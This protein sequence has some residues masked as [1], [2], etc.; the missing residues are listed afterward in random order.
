[1]IDN[2]KSVNLLPEYLKTDKNSKF[3]SGTLDPLIQTPQLER[4]DGFVGSIIT[5]NYNPATDFYLKENLPLRKEYPLEPALVFKDASS[6][7]TDVI[8]FDDIIN[9]I[10]L[11]GGK[12]DN[13]DRLFRSKFYSYNPH[14]D[15]DKLINYNQYYW[16]PNGPDAILVDDLKE[17]IEGTP[18]YIILNNYSLSNGMKLK[19]SSNNKEYYVEGV[20]KSIKLID[21]KL[22]EVHESVAQI[23]NETFD[24][25]LFDSYPFDSNKT[26]PVIPEY[27]TI[28]KASGDL[29]PW[30]RYNR[31]FHGDII[32][33]TAE[34]NN[35]Q[36]VYPLDRRANR[37][38]IEF[39]PDI[40]LYNFGSVGIQNVDIIDTTTTDAFSQVDG[41]IGYYSDE[42]LLEHGFRIIFNADTSLNGKIYKVN[43]DTS[44]NPPTLRLIEPSTPLSASSV[45]INYGILNQGTSWH[46][47]TQ[48]I[49]GIDVIQWKKSQQH[50][51]INQAPLFDLFDNS[52]P[53]Q[54]SYSDKNSNFAGS[55]IFGYEVGTIYDKV[56]GFPLKYKN[57]IGVGSYVFKNYF[58]SDI[59]SITDVNNISSTITT[60]VTYLKIGNEFKNVWEPSVNYQIPIVEIQ[61]M[62]TSTNVLK[63]KSIVTSATSVISYVNGNLVNS[64]LDTD[65]ITIHVSTSSVNIAKNDIVSL[66]II[67]K[68]TPNENGYYKTPLGLTNNPL[69]GPI[70]ELTL[71]EL[72]DHLSTMVNGITGFIGEFP[73][74]S[75][76]RDL[77]DYA[78]YGSRLIINANPIAFP[79]IFLGKKEHNVVDSIRYSAEQYDQFKINFLNALSKVDSQLTPRDALDLVLTQ[80]N[81]SKDSR[82]LY[83]RSDM[84]GYGPNKIVRDYTVTGAN[85][86]FPIGVKFDLTALSFKSVIVYYNDYQL[87]A[88]SEYYFDSIDNTIIVNTDILNLVAGDKISIHYYLDTGGAYIPPTPSKL[89]L[90]PKYKPEYFLDDTYLNSTNVIR[91]HDGSIIKAFDDYRDAIILEY[92]KRVF[93]NIKI[94]YNPKI[95]DVNGY[96]PS[97]FRESKYSSS[98]INDILV[99]DFI[100]WTGQYSIDTTTNNV[101]DE[102]NFFTWNYTNGSFPIGNSYPGYWRGVYKYFYDTD[103]P[104]SHPW[105]MLGHSIKPLW[106]DIQYDWV[107]SEKRTALIDAVT[108]GIVDNL[109]TINSQYARINFSSIVPVDVAGNLKPPGSFL[110]NAGNLTI[111]DKSA[112]WKFGD[113][114]PAETAWRNSSYWPFAVNALSALLDPCSYTSSMFDTSRSYLNIKNQLTYKANDL[115]LNPSK[116]I[117]D[118]EDV[119][120]AG[121]GVYVI[122][123]GKQKDLN[124]LELL[125][126][127]LTYINFNL[128]HKLGGFASKDKLQIVIDSIDPVSQAQGAILP[129]EDYSLIL[130]VSNPIKSAR[131]SGVIV[132]RSN[133][134]FII[135]GYDTTNPYFEILKPTKSLASGAITVGGKSESFTEWTG[136]GNSGNSGLSA[137]D[138][139]STTANTTHYYK[140][141]QIVRYNGTF[142]IVKVGHNTQSTFDITLFQA[143][144][145][146]PMVG[147]ATAQLSS[148]FENTVTVVPYGTS[149]STIQEVYDLLIGYGAYLESQGFIFDEYNTDLNDIV[150]WKFTAKEFLYWTTQNWADGNLITLSPFADYLK[151]SFIDSVVDDITTGDYDF[152]ILK[153][154]GKSFPLD[155]FRL[156]RED[157]VC[158]INTIDTLEGMF[159][160]TLNSVQKEHGMVF[161]NKTIFNDTIYDIETG[162]KQRRIKLS[163]F[164]TANWN[165]DLSSPGFVYDNVTIIDWT[166]YGTYLPGKVVRYNGSYYESTVKII[167]DATFDFE[168]WIKLDSKPVSNLLP[169]FDYKIN[170]FEDFYSLDI[171]NF[172]STQQKLAQHLI[173]YTPRTYLNNIFTNS[174]SQYKFYQGYIKEKGTKNSIDKLS[175]VGKFTRQGDI[176]LTEDWAF[177]SGNY[178]SFSTYNEIEFNLNE[179]TS[180]ENPYLVKFSETPA[181]ANP[182]VTYVSQSDLLL[183]PDSYSSANTFPIMSSSTFFDNNLVLTTAG[184][185]RADD[186]TATAYNKNSLLDIANNSVLQDGN[187]IWMGFLENGG[188]GVSRYS[189]QSS[190]IA[191]VYVSAPGSSITFVTDQP[192]GL[193]IGDIV[194]VVRFN[195][196]VNGIHI[197]I[198]IAKLDQFT[199]ASSLTSIVDAELL[200]YGAL[201]K[202]ENARYKNIKEVANSTDILNLKNNEKIWIDEGINDKWQVYEK[203]KNYSVGVNG[204]F[205]ATITSLSLHSELGKSIYTSDN[206]NILMVSAPGWTVKNT[207]GIGSV[208][209]YTK[210]KT[211]SVLEKKF[212][213]SLNTDLATYC[214]PNIKAQFGYSLQ[215][216]TGKNLYFAG[217]PNATNVVINSANTLTS[218]VVILSTGTG[219][220]KNFSSEGLVKISSINNTFTKETDSTILVNPYATTAQTAN[221]SRFGHS[222]YINETVSTASTTLLVGAPSGPENPTNTGHV[223]AYGVTRTGYYKSTRAEVIYALAANLEAPLYYGEETIL[224]WMTFGLDTAPGFNKLIHDYRLA[225]PNEAA[226]WDIWRINDAIGA[227]ETR[228]TVIRAYQ[229]NPNAQLYPSEED[230]RYW[231]L[232]GLIPY[233]NDPYYVF[234]YVVNLRNTLYPDQYAANIAERAAASLIKPSTVISVHPVVGIE[235]SSHVTLSPGSQFGHKIAGD[236][237]GTV[238]AISAPKHIVTTGTNVGIVQLY[239]KD[240]SWRQ[241]LKSPFGTSSEFGSDVIASPDGSHLF[242]SSTESKSIGEPYGKVAV[243]KKTLTPYYNST[244]PEVIF[245]LAAEELAP[246]YY[247]E[248]TILNWMKV[249]LGETGVFHQFWVDYRAANPADAAIYDAERAADAFNTVA[250]RAAVLAAYFQN[251]DAQLYPDE[252]SIR[253]W[254]LNGLAGFAQSVIDN[255]LL[256]P[257]QYAANLAERSLALSPHPTGYSYELTQIIKNPS[258]TNDLKFGHSISI[259]QD[260]NTL[261]ISALGTNNS[262]ITEFDITSKQ[263]TTTFDEG[264]TQFTESLSDAGTVYVYS[265]LDGH[266]VL[267][268]E[269]VDSSIAEGSKYGSSVIATNNNIYV[270][271]PTYNVSAN[272]DTSSFYQFSK[273][274]S[275]IGSLKLLRQQD[276]LVD[277]STVDRIALIDSFK[278]EIVEYLDVIDPVKGKIAGIAEQELRYKSAFD[279]ATYTVGLAYT[280][281]DSSTSWIDDHVGE[282]WWD[283]STTKYMWYEQGDDIFRKNNW[284]KLF[285]GSSIDVYEWVRSDLLPSE[286]AA[287]ADTNE[288]LTKGISGQPKY[289]DNSV[290][291]IKQL[292]N[293]VTNSFENVYFFWVKNKVTVPATSNRRISSYQVSRIISDPTANGLKFA[294]ILSP[295]SVAFAN[296]QPML[297]GNRI[298]A[299]ITIDTISNTIPKHTEWVL[300]SEGDAN[301]MPTT[302][303]EKKLIDSLL[304][305]DQLGNAVPAINSTYRNRY[306]IGIRPQQTLFKN[307]KEALRNIVEF[308]NS[309]LIK[310]RITG[311]YNFDNLNKLDT[312]PNTFLREYDFSVDHY[313]NLLSV[314]NDI[315]IKYAQAKL[316]CYVTNGKITTVDIVSAGYGYTSPPKV[317]VGLTETSTAEL[318]TE[319]NSEGKVI[320]VII[321]DPGSEFVTAP[322]LTV[323]PHTAIVKADENYKFIWTKYQFDYTSSLWVMIKNQTYNTPL[324]WNYVNWVSDD[325]KLFK[326]YNYVVSHIYELST[327]DSIVPGD[328][329][330]VLNVG[331]GRYVI[332][333]RT[334]NAGNFSKNY[335]IVFSENGTFQILDSIWNYGKLNYS[336]DEATLEETL[337]DQIP[338]LELYYILLAL[339]DDIFIN[340]L[341]VNWNLLFFT[342]VKYALTEQKLLDWAFKTSFINV[343][344][345]VGSLDQRPVYKLEDE[346]NFE[347]YIKEVK[348]YHSQLRS[349]TSKYSYLESTDERLSLSATDF[350]LPSYYNTTTDTFSTVGLQNPLIDQQ[351]WKAWVDNY[352]S[353]IGSIVVSNGGAGYTQTPTVTITGG[354][355]SVISDATA[356]AYIR[357]GTVYQILITSSGN[358][359][360]QA[361][362]VTITG[363]GPSVTSTATAVATLLNLKTR[364]NKIGIKFDRVNYNSEIGETRV[365]DTFICS[366]KDD[367]F[368]LTWLADADKLTVVPTL[369]SKLILGTDYTL[370]Y[371]TEEYNG[372][373][374]KYSRFKFLNYIPIEGQIFKISYNKSIELY[375]ALDRIE[376]LHTSTDSLSS[377]MTGITFPGSVIQGL[378]FEYSVPWDTVNGAGKFDVGGSTWS[379]LVTYYASAKI[380][381]TA[382]IGTSTLYISTTTGIV[383]GQLINI[384]NSSTIRIRPDTVVTSVDT[385]SR[386][387]TISKPIFKIKSAKSTATTVGSQIVVKT[388]T[389][390]NVGGIVAGDKIVIS[391]ITSSGYN[392]TYT[393]DSVLD[394]D[395]FAIKAISSLSTTTA[396]ATTISSATIVTLLSTIDPSILLLDHFVQAYD[397]TTATSLVINLHIQYNDISNIKIFNDGLT[398]PMLTGIPVTGPHP[399]A[400]YYQITKDSNGM[401]LVSFYQLVN[402]SYYFEF[403]IY[404]YPAIEFWKPETMM[405]GLDTAIAGGSWELGNFVGALGVAPEDMIVDGNKFLNLDSSYAPEELVNGHIID[406]LGIN[407]YT[408]DNDSHAMVMTGTF[409]IT[410]GVATTATLLMRP[411]NYDSM[412]VSLGNSVGLNPLTADEMTYGIHFLEGMTATSAGQVGTAILSPYLIGTVDVATPDTLGAFKSNPSYQDAIL[413]TSTGY[414]WIFMNPNQNTFGEIIYSY[415]E[416]RGIP[417]AILDTNQNWWWPSGIDAT[418]G[419]PAHPLAATTNAGF[420][421]FVEMP[422]T[423]KMYGKSVPNFTIASNGSLVFIESAYPYT[424]DIYIDLILKN[425]SRWDQGIYNLQNPAIMV[426]FTD[427]WQN[428]GIGDGGLIPLSSGNTPGIFLSTGVSDAFD[429]I[430]IRFDGTHASNKNQVPTV[431]AIAYEVTLYSNG[432]DQFVEMYYENTYKGSNTNGQPGFVAGI[433]NG[434]GTFAQVPYTEIED[435]SSHVFYSKVSNG[436]QFVYLGK[437]KVNTSYRTSFYGFTS[438]T[439]YFMIGNEIHIPPIP[440]QGVGKYTVVDVG[441]DNSVIDSKMV[442][443][444]NTTTAVLT[445]LASIDDVRKVYVTVNGSEINKVTTSTDY[446]YMLTYVSDQN[447]RAC[448]RVYGLDNTNLNPF[449]IQSWFFESEYTKFNRFHEDIFLIPF[450]GVA[451]YTLPYFPGSSKPVSGQAIVDMYRGNPPYYGRLTPP[452]TTYYKV[453]HGQL[454]YN[455][456]S[457]LVFPQYTFNADNVKVYANGIELRPGF[458]YTLDQVYSTITIVNNLLNNDDVIAIERYRNPMP[459]YSISDN[460]IHF[461]VGLSENNYHARVVSFADHDNMMIRTEKLTTNVYNTNK[462][463]FP[464][465][466]ENYVWVYYNQTPLI[467]RRDFKILDDRRTIVLSNS[468]Y[469]S[470][471]NSL[472]VTTINPPSYGTNVLGYRVFNDMFDRHH[473]G[474]ISS[475]YST[476]LEQPLHYNDTAI[477]VTDASKLVPPNPL[478]NKPGVVIID[479]ERIE[480]FIKDG[481]VLRQL[482]RGTLGTAPAAISY[483]GTSVIDQSPQQDVPY[484]ESVLVQTTSTTSLTY[485]ISTITNTTTG[486]GIKLTP[487]VNAVD[488]VTVYYGGRQLRKTPLIIHDSAI[489][490]DPS[491]TSEVILPPEF[492]ITTATNELVLNILDVTS[493]NTNIT[494]VQR[495]GYVWT[496]TESLLTSNAIQAHFLREKEAS[497]PNQYYYGG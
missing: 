422:F 465:L 77:N 433:T 420:S 2:K 157:G 443:V 61:T 357:N 285:P 352:T 56:L 88:N 282:L 117:L 162:Y 16:L 293:N 361:P 126:Q 123:R 85:N 28:N 458:D 455:I 152:S 449:T 97:A 13:L 476:T 210:H 140:Q 90:Y 63:L 54:L 463:S 311:N 428:Y 340:N 109:G 328:Y 366:G 402:S 405:S 42:V 106:W 321:S 437:G 78:K 377:L 368:V 207:P 92:E 43:Y 408:K 203:I 298:N 230:I 417:Y 201:F 193:S 350:D 300:L 81:S 99:K 135:K 128:F 254:M 177:R 490:Y 364:K 471:G 185:I 158:V 132:Q 483:A 382:T 344:N 274:D 268:E 145:S 95:F 375:T 236:T 287:Q 160:A 315:T 369:D 199:V 3:L 312:V 239:D 46:Y 438:P 71:S 153:A 493:N 397:K 75:N 379:E 403:F 279:P 40:K 263:G 425:A 118:G 213:Y 320:N 468:L 475:F 383:T 413:E 447:N 365:F 393:V 436:G 137:I 229:I 37:P 331:D 440:Y 446:G 485:T 68:D 48:N 183:T 181:D 36:A 232:N 108:N 410:A 107:N 389:P 93:N 32:R 31:W 478:T 129:P 142:Y 111:D 395:Q 391:G 259:S 72:S 227:V 454:T 288:G 388:M 91:G 306:G 8:G 464:V 258:Y 250:T 295:S 248:E 70:T 390:F 278:E 450:E 179:S 101:Y 307:R 53:T 125:T 486:D 82:S 188:W 472:I 424:A 50:T 323:R 294:E 303:L 169:N 110:L 172:D 470:P 219:Y 166:A 163:G 415:Y 17:D 309:V 202:F 442:V 412:I 399:G 262:I 223:Y 143:L 291:S 432:E 131:I 367:K 349:Y 427:L 497:L 57:S 353:E 22:L 272:N 216:D 235:L 289:P 191:G 329:V 275:T 396:V 327:L 231:M 176:L 221:Y 273:I 245:S 67:S 304:G 416:S 469:L 348:P 487:G 100:K 147:G 491:A 255:N 7:I 355:G 64:T 86:I 25:D 338:D 457:V 89:G 83:Y 234:N 376:K 374:K 39:N 371:Y 347:E 151:Y 21:I 406:S 84:L 11:Q 197:I 419:D 20:G 174:I 386:S 133:G 264:T 211:T 121:F 114:S 209:V 178:G 237:T 192:H 481:N 243:Y 249:G 336:Y 215:Y 473:Y 44:T 149:Y 398:S 120:S 105:E 421:Q 222:I 104:H 435:F 34:I 144:P 218:G 418:Y 460:M 452:T 224:N 301:S 453:T 280:I 253:Y 260:N 354:G 208:W 244:R 334:E 214:Y 30:T 251:P 448:V 51:T 19:L 136:A 73:G 265:N 467:P 171:D 148:R 184:Y 55:K 482:R 233:G 139:T 297:V 456:D 35:Q 385:G 358:G 122:E 360:T 292:F 283:L 276:D 168:K 220:T 27:I 495:K 337:Y 392:G 441:G 381:S 325:Y 1:M 242:V 190:K 444:D 496:G 49:N 461:D 74:I 430:R 41:T 290:V 225:N 60:G 87:I 459:E 155:K 18:T 66:E 281:V 15:W 62:L 466:N 269:L 240:F 65:G 407:V 14:I 69:N 317:T 305:H 124:Y 159:F 286:W 138:I 173:G 204:H 492:T 26:L 5:P 134:N 346:Q 370:E 270:G 23:Y 351:P 378:P 339:K 115:Y 414:L 112:N 434:R 80:L 146:L 256:N 161:N 12:T 359:Y 226:I 175:K 187:T 141:G 479:G 167:G 400:E 356:S 431:P 299:N 313:S 342:A 345:V 330:K 372:Y 102:Y 318:L 195:E 363:G 284:G 252:A 238:I 489:S 186:V 451:S 182:L 426:E 343:T 79:Q 58:M 4:I 228:A 29:N 150:N 494:I 98:E 45:S 423:F 445:S 387:I 196:Q 246:V 247:G 189:K 401:A 206:T 6:N 296:V 165:G 267:S 271:A 324:Y 116:L 217:A 332:L 474:R 384:L 205:T 241:T 310:N 198:D 404:G 10:N 341:K 411:N 439:Q 266:F 59:V 314:S 316:E 200:S 409:P 113:H 462:L 33:I 38:I 52:Q 96:L 484:T 257:A 154:D 47:T 477:Y 380:I 326:E 302:L 9:E 103:R 212:E 373:N 24:S 94:N 480:F 76:L 261:S 394:A 130:N 119:Q 322:I 127:D 170:Q 429:Y 277:I 156:S 488:Q 180:L 164:R 335:N 319:I 333:E 194:S 362:T 308:A